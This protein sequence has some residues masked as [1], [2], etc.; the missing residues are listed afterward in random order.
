[1][2][3]NINSNRGRRVQ[4]PGRAVPFSM[5][6][7]PFIAIDHVQLAMPVGEEEVARRF[8]RDLL[9]MAEVPKPRELAKR[10]GC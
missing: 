8:Y 7:P 2:R 9:G 3:V 4:N 5:D 1:M 10:G 6:E